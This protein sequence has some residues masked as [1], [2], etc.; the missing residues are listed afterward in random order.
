[1]AVLG[2]SL[3][4]FDYEL[5]SDPDRGTDL[6]TKFTLQVLTTK[7][8]L[9][10][11]DGN[12]KFEQKFKGADDSS[13]NMDVRTNETQ[14]NTIRIGLKGW[15]NFKK[16]N[17]EDVPFETERGTLKGI[18]GTHDLVSEKTMNYLPPKF[19]AELA[20]V[21]ENGSAVEEEDEKN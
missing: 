17:G 3:E 11:K 9:A 6:A 7:V 1:M 5:K 10:F 8:A 19:W 13:I 21:I 12:A 20:R 14:V 16:P 18:P 15:T 2:L 4:Q